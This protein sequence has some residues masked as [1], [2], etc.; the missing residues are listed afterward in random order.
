MI[1]KRVDLGAA[2]PVYRAKWDA[3]TQYEFLNMVYHN[4]ALWMCVSDSIEIGDEPLGTET[5]SKISANGTWVQLGGESP[6]F[7]PHMTPDGILSWTNT[8]NLENPETVDLLSQVHD[9]L[10]SLNQANESLNEM[11]AEVENDLSDAKTLVSKSNSNVMTVQNLLR[12][13][14]SSEANAALSANQAE[15]AFHNTLNA[16]EDSGTISVN[17]NEEGF[18]NSFNVKDGATLNVNITGQA[19]SAV[20]D[21]KGNAIDKSYLSLKG[22]QMSGDIVTT[23]TNPL[24]TR[25]SG[26]DST[27]VNMIQATDA[28]NTK[29]LSV[30]RATK[31]EEDNELLI[32]IFSPDDSSTPSGIGI[33]KSN[34]KTEV[35]LPQTV[36]L[37]FSPNK[38]DISTQV[39]TTEWVSSYMPKNHASSGTSY[40]VATASAYG[41]AK[42]SSSIPRTSDVS[43]NAGTPNGIYA[44]A[45][46]VHPYPAYASQATYDSEG[47]DITQTYIPVV[48]DISSGIIGTKSATSGKTV[49]IPYAVINDYGLVISHGTHT[50]TI[51]GFLSTDYKEYTDSD[52]GASGFI[53]YNSGLQMEWGAGTTTANSSIVSFP[54][55]FKKAPIVILTQTSD[56][57]SVGNS[58]TMKAAKVTTTSFIPQAIS[59]GSLMS[60]TF[61]YIAI[62]QGV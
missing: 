58:F 2:R 37:D 20:N 33:R 28:T 52:I 59:G 19:K 43:G 10:D 48:A 11:Q 26:T 22:G 44:N 15:E 7:T 50:H 42:A 51:E 13:A 38:S 62:G 40:G 36:L 24:T 49:S 29:M 61:S 18:A 14:Q 31:G 9:A 3:S 5:D 57:S 45:D 55:P 23:T 12:S 8:G 1:V 32:G 21:S 17:R 56:T 27:F 46:H 16:F 41:H 47:R 30:F 25:L 35:F 4:T 60:T 34:E 6:Y 53:T 39:A 54:K